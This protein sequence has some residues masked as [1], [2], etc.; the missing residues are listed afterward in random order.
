MYSRTVVP[1]AVTNDWTFHEVTDG[2]CDGACKDSAEEAVCA[3]DE[4]AAAAPIAAA[5]DATD[6]T[7]P[8][9]PARALVAGPVKLAP[10]SSAVTHAFFQRCLVPGFIADPI[11]RLLST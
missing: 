8:P 6:A 10:M 1:L 11:F 4:G 9:S 3:S 7:L 2:V 5:S